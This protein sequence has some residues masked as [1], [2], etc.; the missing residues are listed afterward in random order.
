MI[1]RAFDCLERHVWRK[2]AEDFRQ[3]WKLDWNEKGENVSGAD[4]RRH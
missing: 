3:S 1:S 4:S 2:N